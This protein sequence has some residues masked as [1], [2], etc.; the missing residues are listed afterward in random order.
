MILIKWAWPEFF[1]AR[2]LHALL[3][4]PHH[5]KSPRSALDMRLQ[6]QCVQC[7][8]NLQSYIQHL[9]IHTIMHTYTGTGKSH[10][11]ALIS[12]KDRPACRQSTALATEADQII[13][14]ACVT[15]DFEEEIV[16]F[17]RSKS[18][19]KVKW[20]VVSGKKLSL[21]IAKTIHNQTKGKYKYL[22]AYRLNCYYPTHA[23]A[24]G[25]AIGHVL[26]I[27]STNITRS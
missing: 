13:P 4:H 20:L 24:R 3:L 26:V 27:V 5:S 14:A 15:H 22:L 12:G 23:C 25:K 16:E 18:G 10:F 21:L 7:D 8:I 1:F 6:V 9:Y 11:R 19:S 17:H 2:A